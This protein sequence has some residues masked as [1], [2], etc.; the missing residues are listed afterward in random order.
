VNTIIESPNIAPFR[1]IAVGD[2]N[3][4]PRVV[5]VI[6]EGTSLRLTQRSEYSAVIQRNNGQCPRCSRHAHQIQHW[7]PAKGADPRGRRRRPG[8]AGRKRRPRL[9]A[10]PTRSY[11]RE[12]VGHTALHQG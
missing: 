3:G 10:P 12:P 9:H 1:S 11:R 8:P 6:A 2:V 7:R 5:D 4:Q